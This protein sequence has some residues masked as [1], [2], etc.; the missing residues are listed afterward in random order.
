MNGT[1]GLRDCGWG[2]RSTR[3]C[4]LRCALTVAS[5]FCLVSAC[6]WE[7]PFPDYRGVN[8]ITNRGFSVDDFR[9]AYDNGDDAAASDDYIVLAIPDDVGSL[10]GLPDESPETIATIR[11]LEVVNLIP[12]GDFETGASPWITTGL[13]G[14]VNAPSDFEIES[15]GVLTG[16]YVSFDVSANQ[17]A[18]INLDTSMLIP[19]VHDG[20]YF[21]QALVVREESTTDITFDY[22]DDG[23]TS[24][25][26]LNTISWTSMGPEDG[27]DP[28]P[29]LLPDP[30]V[31]YRDIGMQFT[32]TTTPSYFYL[33]SPRDALSQAGYLDDVR[34]GRLDNRPVLELALALEDAG[35]LPLPSGNYTFSVYVK[36]EVDS[37]V[38][39]DK[40]NRFRAGQIAIGANGFRTLFTQQEHGWS[41]ST[42]VRLQTVVRVTPDDV[43]EAR[44]LR[45]QLTTVDPSRPAVGSI[46]IANPELS[47][48]SP[49]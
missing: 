48:G 4:R 20:K 15:E 21:A 40:P 13:A 11:S 46:L 26:Y 31:D 19:L 27:S 38:T 34:I 5:L 25:N 33:G 42:W 9:E 43:L 39:P 22:G 16:S 32:V 3:S 36:S 35:G 10:A 45:L 7:V 18:A 44:P 8:L 24:Y 17:G 23:T 12:N 47:I 14:G 49:E 29:E 1:R 30:T 28:S 6:E 41:E 2:Y 37:E